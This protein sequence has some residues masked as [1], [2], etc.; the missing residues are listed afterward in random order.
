VHTDLSIRGSGIGE[1]LL[2]LN[3][4]RIND[5]QTAHHDMD[6]AVPLEAVARVETMRGSGSTMYGSDAAGG[7]VNIVTEKPER[8]EVRLRAAAGNIGM[9]QQSG[10][11][12]G[13]VGAVAERLVFSRDFSSGF[14]PDRDY[15]NLQLASMTHVST[16]LGPAD[17]TL[18]YADRPFGA[19]QFY[20]N[21]NSWENTKTWFASAQQSI[22]TKTTASFSYRR[23]S[24]LFV[25]YRDRPEL[26]VNRHVSETW[27]A[28]ARRR[29]NIMVLVPGARATGPTPGRPGHG[30]DTLGP[31]TPAP[32]E[33]DPRRWN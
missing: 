32:V 11:I 4:Q 16:G 2:L 13:G 20:G 15:R 18:A 17:F 5:P 7:V 12:A 8:T 33:P 14:M 19:G 31:S 1:T 9:N 28:A 6:I 24:D 3:G 23:H 29:A 25:L 21:F 22:G 27:Q 26:Y 30:D 10:S